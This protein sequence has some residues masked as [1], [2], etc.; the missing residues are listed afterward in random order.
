[1]ALS[2][3]ERKYIN[4]YGNHK[5]LDEDDKTFIGLYYYYI[6]YKK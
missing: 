4:D 6:F 5:E 1:M 2:D 3:I